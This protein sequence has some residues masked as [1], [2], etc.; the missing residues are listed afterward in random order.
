[1]HI[2]RAESFPQT[3]I[4]SLKAGGN[5][6]SVALSF[7]VPQREGTLLAAIQI[8]KTVHTI[9]SLTCT[10]TLTPASLAGLLQ[11]CTGPS[12]S[13]LHLSGLRCEIANT[14]AET[15]FRVQPGAA[16]VLQSAVTDVTLSR[17]WSAETSS[18]RILEALQHCTKLTCA[19]TLCNN[20]SM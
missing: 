8:L 15:M 11:L 17:V 20:Y 19:L 10:Y 6:Q 16:K 18:R 2:T 13:S 3:Q 14:L 9:S 7:T 4:C 5:Q 1:V 12:F